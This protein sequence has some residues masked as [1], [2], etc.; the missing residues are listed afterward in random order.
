MVE[1]IPYVGKSKDF[2]FVL[3]H[4]FHKWVIDTLETNLSPV[5]LEM[6]PFVLWTHP[7]TLDIMKNSFYEGARNTVATTGTSLKMVGHFYL[8][9]KHVTGL[10]FYSG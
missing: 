1:K 8:T 7:P 4:I 2:K 3:S 9:L 6:L 10:S 5:K